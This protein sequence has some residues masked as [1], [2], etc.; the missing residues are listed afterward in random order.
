MM[1]WKDKPRDLD[2]HLF[3]FNCN[4]LALVTQCYWRNKAQ[5]LGLEHGECLF[6]DRDDTQVR[7][8][9][10]PLIIVLAAC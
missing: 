6:L 7:S 5:S 8:G 3:S 1:Q 9:I 2:L 10:M 4:T